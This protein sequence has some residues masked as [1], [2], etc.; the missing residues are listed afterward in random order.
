MNQNQST[1][2]SLPGVGVQGENSTRERFNSAGVY[3]Q[4]PAEVIDWT[5]PSIVDLIQSVIDLHS[6]TAP[7]DS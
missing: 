2:L 4:S 6:A 1:T 3:G 5:N 7:C